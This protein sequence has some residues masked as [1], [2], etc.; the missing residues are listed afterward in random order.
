MFD[1][2]KCKDKEKE[3][4][5]QLARGLTNPKSNTRKLSNKK[6]KIKI[7]TPRTKTL[8]SFFERFPNYF[9]FFQNL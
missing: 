7:K 9:Q 3:K 2:L 1:L 6:K 8:T 5:G 4:N